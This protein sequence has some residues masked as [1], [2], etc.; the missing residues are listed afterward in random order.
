MG[1][2]GLLIADK[3]G[4]E[5]PVMGS[6]P[7]VDRKVRAYLV[8]HQEGRRWVAHDQ[9]AERERFVLAADEDARTCGAG[10][11]GQRPEERRLPRAGCIADHGERLASIQRTHE[12]IRLYSTKHLPGE[13]IIE[14]G[15]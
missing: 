10:G 15:R 6:T 14:R 2:G 4:T 12:K 3:L 9:G 11:G 8:D 7:A 13:E 5:Q 1:S